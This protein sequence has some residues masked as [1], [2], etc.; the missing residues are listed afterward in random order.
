MNVDSSSPCPLTEQK[1]RWR[2]DTCGNIFVRKFTLDRHKKIHEK[3]KKKKTLITCLCCP[4]TFFK[5]SR[6]LRHVQTHTRKKYECE[7]CGKKYVRE[8]Y[9]SQHRQRCA[10]VEQ[11]VD[12]D[13]GLDCEDDALE[14]N[15]CPM[16]DSTSAIKPVAMIHGI[17]YGFSESES[18][19]EDDSE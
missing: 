19:T 10:A 11:V 18:D 4:K 5:K 14:D 7:R 16:P 12:S 8:M 9:F 17:K 13:T 6:M 1:K 3:P 2:C 15:L